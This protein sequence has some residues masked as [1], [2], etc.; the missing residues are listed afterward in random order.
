MSV[1]YSFRENILF[2]INKKYII[3]QHI[4]LSS[5]SLYFQ[6]GFNKKNY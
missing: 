6:I 1:A 3:F 4:Y 5:T 2:S